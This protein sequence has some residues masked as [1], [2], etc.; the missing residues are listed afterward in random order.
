LSTRNSGKI[1][2][3]NEKQETRENRGARVR[4]IV[5]SQR[6]NS[7]VKLL[8]ISVIKAVLHVQNGI[9]IIWD[10][11]HP[12]V[13]GHSTPRRDGVSSI[14]SDNF[15]DDSEENTV[16]DGEGIRCNEETGI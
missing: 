2:L 4:D 7:S 8:T 1:F 16:D 5:Y 11:R 3:A 9:A 10:N 13:T 15:N 14:G 6:F 12:L